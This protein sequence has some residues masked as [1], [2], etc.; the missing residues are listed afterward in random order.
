MGKKRKP[1]YLDESN[2]LDADLAEAA[3]ASDRGKPLGP[4]RHRL[5]RQLASMAARV[6]RAREEHE[7]ATGQKIIVERPTAFLP[8]DG[9]ER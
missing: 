7:R 6:R 4:C 5:R 3:K 2:T 8:D 9:V 1:A